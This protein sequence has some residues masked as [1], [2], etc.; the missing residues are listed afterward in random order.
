MRMRGL[1]GITMI[2]ALCA[3]PCAASPQT[4][5]FPVLDSTV[6]MLSPDVYIAPGLTTGADYVNYNAVARVADAGTSADAESGGAWAIVGMGTVSVGYKRMVTQ[7]TLHQPSYSGS[8]TYDADVYTVKWAPGKRIK[9]LPANGQLTLG[10]VLYFERT[11]HNDYNFQQHFAALGFDFGEVRI[12]GG[13]NWTEGLLSGNQGAF[14]S[15]QWE[16]VDNWLLFADYSRKDFNKLVINDLL[17][18]RLGFDCS[19]CPDDATSVGLSARLDNNI[20]ATA[21]MYDTNDVE[22]FM[23]SLSMKW[24]H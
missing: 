15:F 14:A 23:G 18:P 1:M 11:H 5:G 10:S 16:L 6:N 8:N 4:L 21:G 24:T 12:K 9:M 22:A 7:A 20:F 3:A 19:R 17:L 2:L 13:Y